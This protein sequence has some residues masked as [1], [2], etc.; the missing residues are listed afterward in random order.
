[1]SRVP[2]LDDKILSLSELLERLAPRRSAGQRLVLTNGCFDLVHSGHVRY[3][4]AAAELG[5]L[6][7]IG[8]N[9]DAS[10][11]QLKEP[12]RPLV[13]QAE[14][15]TVLAGL[16][17]VD[18]LTIFDELTAEHLVASLRPDVYVKGGDYATHPP[19]EAAVAKRLG[20]EFKLLPLVEGVSTSELVRRIRAQ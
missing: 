15:A 17:C 4:A 19:S 10:V 1:V 16:G 14:R 13:S 11:R 3:L 20:A 8:L 7:V 5:D 2:P 18:Y 9:S 12:G 6:L